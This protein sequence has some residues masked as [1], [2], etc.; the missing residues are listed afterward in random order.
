MCVV[1]CSLWARDSEEMT[2]YKWDFSFAGLAFRVEG[3]KHLISP[4]E[5]AWS[6]WQS[7]SKVQ[8]WVLSIK[9]D[10]YPAAPNEALFQAKPECLD[11]ICTLQT[12]GF[13]ARIDAQKKYGEMLTNPAATAADVDYFLR[14]AVALNAFTQFSFLFHAA[15]VV[16]NEK[17]YLLFGLSG[18]GKTTAAKLS[19]PDPVLNDDLLLLKP[20][21][22]RWLVYSTP[23]G[24]R[25]DTRLVAPLFAALRLVQDKDV[26]LEPLSRGRALTELLAN[27][28]IIS[29]DKTLLPE[30]MTRWMQF[31]DRIPVRALHFR[32]DST[33]W[34]VIDAEWE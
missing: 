25:R 34:E 29:V 32:K 20:D 28:P 13:L 10:E 17:G 24:K 11:G 2:M 15:C 27:T 30:L 18:S 31:I 8:P 9:T 22:G 4:L 21:G 1:N 23:F 6:P 7:D 3:P 14:V 12:H 33:F 5:K 19:Y 26:F 16:H